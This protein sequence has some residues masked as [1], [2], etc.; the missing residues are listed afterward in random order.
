[1]FSMQ[2]TQQA[3]LIPAAASSLSEGL[4]LNLLEG[5]RSAFAEIAN[6]FGEVGFGTPLV[7][8]VRRTDGEGLLIIAKV[9][10]VILLQ[11]IKAFQVVAAKMQH[12]SFKKSCRA[13][14]AVVARVDRGV[15][16]VSDG[17]LDGYGPFIVG[18]DPGDK[19]LHQARHIFGFRWHIDDAVGTAVANN[20]RP[21]R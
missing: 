16:I 1:M 18:I 17:G 8:V 10:G 2:L 7:V 12:S 11:R 3:R 5:K 21:S 9:I 6:P 4:A 13:P 19:S 20:V 15:W 14:I